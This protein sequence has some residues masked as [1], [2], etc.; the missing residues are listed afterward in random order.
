MQEDE[1]MEMI[2]NMI[3]ISKEN[4]QSAVSVEQALKLV[5]TEMMQRVF[6]DIESPGYAE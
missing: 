5:R 2:K 4:Y 6:R 1:Y 3:N